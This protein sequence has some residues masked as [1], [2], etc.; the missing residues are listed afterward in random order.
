MKKRQLLICNKSLLWVSP[1]VLASGIMLEHLHG[2]PFRG[3][4]NAVFTWLHIIAS[5]IMTGLVVWHLWLN[6]HGISK[7]YDRFKR[8]HSKAVKSMAMF[9]TLT[10][11]TGLI[12]VPLW[13]THGHCGIG[14]LHGKFGYIAAVFTF[15]HIVKHWKWYS[16]N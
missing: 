10:V 3:I 2:A 7:W 1:I 16:R 11:A 6:W 15:L 5:T 12:A 9:F 13:L 4:G 8:H 14:G